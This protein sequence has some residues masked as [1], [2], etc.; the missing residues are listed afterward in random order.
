MPFSLHWLCDE[1]QE[2]RAEKSGDD[3][4]L[5]LMPPDWTWRAEGDGF[6]YTCPAC[7]QTRTATTARVTRGSGKGGWG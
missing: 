7:S 6:R 1:C 5:L 2:V 4:K 3:S